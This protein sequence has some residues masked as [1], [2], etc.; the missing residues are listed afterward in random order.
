MNNL[1]LQDMQE[2]CYSLR[3]MC[4]LIMII[5]SRTGRKR[6]ANLNLTVSWSLWVYWLR[7]ESLRIFNAA[8]LYW[9]PKICVSTLIE[10]RNKESQ[11]L[12]TTNLGSNLKNT[13]FH[14]ILKA[15][16]SNTLFWLAKIDTKLS[17]NISVWSYSHIQN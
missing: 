7:E 6:V 12:Q 8:R 1:N 16:K 13:L 3:M 4:P 17:S 10:D 2:V 5:D 9:V 14:R 11:D 15:T